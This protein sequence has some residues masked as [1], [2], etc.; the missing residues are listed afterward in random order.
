MNRFVQRRSCLFL[1]VMWMFVTTVFADA[2]NI[3]DIFCP[4]VLH[5]DGEVTEGA[6]PPPTHMGTHPPL[7]SRFD[8]LTPGLLRVIIDQDSPSL[9]VDV[10]VLALVSQILPGND[11][12]A[13]YASPFA[14]GTLHIKLHTLL[15]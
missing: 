1:V 2:A 3:D 8:A 12:Q 4:T 5:D 6:A 15:I 7:L 13:S 9:P 10:D 14:S 11:Q